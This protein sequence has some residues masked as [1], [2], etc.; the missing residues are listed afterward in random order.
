MRESKGLEFKESVSATFL[1]T[2][3][4]FAN[5]GGGRILFGVA[6]DGA[7]VGLGNPE[8]ACLDIENRINDCITPNPDYSLAVN[9]DATVSLTVAEGLHKPY[10]YKAKAYKRNGTATIAV[11]SAE[12]S[13][14]V[15]EG[16]NLD[17]EDLP[18]RTGRLSFSV[19]EGALCEKTG[20]SGL[21][22]D[23]LRTLELEN[24]RGELN[25]AAELLADE[26]SFPG[27]DAV[28]FGDSVNV[29]LDRVSTE[30]VS[31]LTQYD[32]AVEMYGK[33]YQYEEIVGS[34]REA[35]ELVPEA[36]FREALANALVHR[37]WDARAN[38]RVSMHPDRIEV[39]S[40]GSLPRGI[41]EQEYL[42]GR[43]SSLRNPILGNVFFRLGLMERF[44]TGVLRIK[45]SYASSARKP[46]FHVGENSI[47]VV[48]PTQGDAD[49][50]SPDERAVL[51]ALT[52]SELPMSEITKRSGF[53]KTKCQ[54]ILTSLIQN[55]YASK[56]GNGRGTRYRRS[57]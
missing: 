41:S 50:L 18:S 1:K 43:I 13:R 51:D 24:R 7:A 4:A 33:Y 32:A 20:I 55:G 22:D 12:L 42:S 8:Q 10:L 35:R 2:V 54:G 14:L 45:E 17:F 48:L 53:G 26:N 23:V 40:P 11:G 29:F 28:R 27:V 46:R 25:I 38:V 49:D 36:A 21:D 31:V 34:R 52:A 47:T 16:S 5:Y 15:L 6:D 30:R 56:V 9:A 57:M 19:L 37:E 3:S 44:G 39:V